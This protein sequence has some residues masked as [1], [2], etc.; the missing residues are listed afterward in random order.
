MKHL[1]PIIEERREKNLSGSLQS[2]DHEQPV[3]YR[4]KY[5]LSATNYSQNDM[6]S[7]LMSEAAPGLEQ[8]TESIVLRMLNINFLAIHTT[9]MVCSTPYAQTEK[10]SDPKFLVIG[11]CSFSPGIEARIP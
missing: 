6:L 9:S 2:D 10:P 7:W 1:A 8:T 11:S 4:Q 3:R 5:W